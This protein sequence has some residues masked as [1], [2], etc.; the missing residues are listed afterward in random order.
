MKLRTTATIAFVAL[1]SLKGAT[2]KYQNWTELP[3][4][5]QTCFT[6]MVTASL[7]RCDEL[8]LTCFCDSDSY[9]AG[10]DRCLGLDPSCDFTSV[11]TDVDDYQSNIF[12]DPSVDSGFRLV[13][14]DGNETTTLGLP[15]AAIEVSTSSS[16][17]S[18]EE[19]TTA[20][21]TNASNSSSS[22]N[23]SP[24]SA[25]ATPSSS[26]SSSS[27]SSSSSSPSGKTPALKTSISTVVVELSSIATT[28]ST[29]TVTVV[30]TTTPEAAA[31]P[32][33]TTPDTIIT[34]CI[35]AVVI[36]LLAKM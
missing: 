8:S 21:S 35:W 18:D 29:P 34:F 3:D 27:S 22:S 7:T 10:F 12:C 33:N 9:T 32:S 31:V 1:F 6:Q 15:S 28:S 11:K 19:T 4:C 36:L 2:A 23:R 16:A 20:S 14:T 5:A 25:S 13:A 24:A 30:V 17:D 26:T